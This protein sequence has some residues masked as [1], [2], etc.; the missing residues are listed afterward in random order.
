MKKLFPVL[1]LF[2]CLVAAPS[3]AGSATWLLNP[4][5]NDWNTATN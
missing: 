3:F 5:T 2:S 4:V 1:Y